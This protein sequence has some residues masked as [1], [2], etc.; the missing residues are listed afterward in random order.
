MLE[1]F[2]WFL[3]VVFEMGSFEQ[4]SQKINVSHHP[5]ANEPFVHDIVVTA[6]KNKKK[7]GLLRSQNTVEYLWTCGT[8]KVAVKG[9]IVQTWKAKT[10]HN[11]RFGHLHHFCP[12]FLVLHCGSPSDCL[13]LLA[14][15]YGTNVLCQPLPWYKYYLVRVKLAKSNNVLRSSRRNT[16]AS[17]THTHSRQ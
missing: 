5:L 2:Y 14:F 16:W 13:L 3:E 11:V 12:I 10:Q 7:G 4:K 1:L 15:S 8:S 6:T 17:F 9:K